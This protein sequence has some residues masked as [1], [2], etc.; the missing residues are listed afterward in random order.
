[1]SRV[2]VDVVDGWSPRFDREGEFP[3]ISPQSKGIA[4]GVGK[5]FRYRNVEAI[6]H[7]NSMWDDGHTLFVVSVF[8]HPTGPVVEARRHHATSAIVATELKLCGDSHGLDVLKKTRVLLDED[9]W[10][11]GKSKK[12][13]VAKC[14]NPVSMYHSTRREDSECGPC[15]ARMIYSCDSCGMPDELRTQ[16]RERLLALNRCWLCDFWI[17]RSKQT[18]K[19]VVISEDYRF[20]SIANEASSGSRGFGGANFLVTF[21][22]GRTVKT[23]NLWSGG[24]IPEALYHLFEPNAK[25]ESIERPKPARP[26]VAFNG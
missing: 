5:E 4:I 7:K 23:S 26:P 14:A 22:D 8:D 20:L 21:N 11:V 6:D 24:S 17:T 3:L 15:E 13:K 19:D 9:G 18:S 2:Q 10:T 12:C 16:G 1:M 25:I